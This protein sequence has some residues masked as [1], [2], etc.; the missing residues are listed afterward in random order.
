[1]TESERLFARELEIL[2]RKTNI[3]ELQKLFVFLRALHEALWQLFFN[4]RKPL[5]Q[6]LRYSIARIRSVPSPAI[7]AG[8]VQG[9]IIH[10]AEGFLLSA[11]CAVQDTI[12]R[13]RE[14]PK[15]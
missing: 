9:R 1:M 6:Q 10:E 14:V 7:P 5:L 8:A 13:K 4:G 12:E 15:A 3:R 2:F 11:S